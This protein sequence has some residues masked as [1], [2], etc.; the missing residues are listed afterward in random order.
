[1]ILHF[2]RREFVASQPARLKATP[3]LTLF[4]PGNYD[5]SG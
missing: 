5:S 1:M 2:V 3:A 4:P